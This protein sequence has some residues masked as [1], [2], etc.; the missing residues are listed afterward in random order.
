MISGNDMAVAPP[1]LFSLFAPLALERHEVA[2]FAYFDANGQLIG[3][4]HV[5]DERCDAVALPIRHIAADAIA[6]DAASVAM[7]HN[8]P[9]GDPAFSAGDLAATRRL[10]RGLQALGVQLVDHLLLTADACT[11]LRSLSLL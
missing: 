2:G 9:S 4:R 3:L 7:A 6:L 5:R 10:A 8:H 11:S 1:T